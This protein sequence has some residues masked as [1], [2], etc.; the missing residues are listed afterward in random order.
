MSY[1]FKWYYFLLIIIEFLS[2]LF[3]YICFLT[4]FSSE[5]SLYEVFKSSNEN[6]KMYVPA[7]YTNAYDSDA[8]IA[9]PWCILIERKVY[10][11]I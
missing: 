3:V 2:P 9:K 1:Q 8:W 11:S 6:M 5:S 4:M 7:A 10:Y